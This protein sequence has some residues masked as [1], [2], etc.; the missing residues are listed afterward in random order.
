MEKSAKRDLFVCAL[1]DIQ[2]VA[3]RREFGMAWICLAWNCS[4]RGGVPFVGNFVKEGGRFRK[5]SES[6]LSC[7]VYFDYYIVARFKGKNHGQRGI[8]THI[9]YRRDIAS[10]RKYKKAKQP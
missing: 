8:R 9:D 4:K 1:P 7:A 5:N 10:K 6:R 3:T 2:K